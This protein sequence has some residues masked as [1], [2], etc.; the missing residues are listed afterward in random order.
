[1]KVAKATRNNRITNTPI[2]VEI[3]TTTI[4]KGRRLRHLPGNRTLNLPII[5]RLP[6]P[7]LPVTLLRADPP[8]KVRIIR[9]DSLLR[10]RPK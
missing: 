10:R 6:R 7:P 8:R 9:F 2:E 5:L 3:I 1:M 4:E